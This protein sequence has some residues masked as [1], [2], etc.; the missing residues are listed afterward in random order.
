MAEKGSFWASIT[1]YRHMKSVFHNTKNLV[2]GVKDVEHI[3]ETFEEAIK[4]HKIKEENVESHLKMV[5]KGLLKEF[6]TLFI[7][8][9]ILLYLGVYKS[10]D[11]ENYMSLAFSFALIALFLVLMF[12]KGHRCYQINKRS[13]ENTLKGYIATPSQ[14]FP[15][16]FLEKSDERTT[17]SR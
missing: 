7:F 5:Y 2:K 11:N 8:V 1:G 10:I 9:L 13:L 14:W 4:R 15:K 6:Y 17:G 16:K 12:D 3:E